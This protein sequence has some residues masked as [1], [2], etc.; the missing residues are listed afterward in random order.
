MSKQCFLPSGSNNLVTP[1]S[2]ST[3]WNTDSKRSRGRRD[4]ASRQS[5]RSGRLRCTSAE[6]AKPSRQ[7]DVKSFTRTPGQRAVDLRAH[8]SKASRAVRLSSWP[9][10]ISE[11]Y[12]KKT[13]QMKNREININ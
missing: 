11:I 6:K 2:L 12:K 10:T 5:M 8:L 1:Y 3:A 7:D 13:K 4:L 9:T